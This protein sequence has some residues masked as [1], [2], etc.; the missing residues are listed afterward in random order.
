MERKI[1][2]SNIVVSFDVKILEHSY[3]ASS[4]IKFSNLKTLF[5][6]STLILSDR[7]MKMT[8]TVAL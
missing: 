4:T 2:G 5:K 8:Y 3:T 6:K 7:H 1:D